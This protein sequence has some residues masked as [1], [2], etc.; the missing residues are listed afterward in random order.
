MI[1]FL[2]KHPCLGHLKHPKKNTLAKYSKH[3]KLER[4]VN[5]SRSIYD[6]LN[7]AT[8]HN[9]NQKGIENDNK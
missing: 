8:E 2:M 3:A 4:T 6:Q 1:G 5:T 9:T 7:H